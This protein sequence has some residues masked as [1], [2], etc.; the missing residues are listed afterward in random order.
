[1]I[2]GAQIK[3]ISHDC[4]AYE[5]LDIEEEP[6]HKPWYHDILTYVKSQEYPSHATENDKKTIR[7]LAMGFCL[8]GNILYKRTF[9]GLLLRCLDEKEAQRV[10]QE[11]TKGAVLH[12]PV[13][14][15]WLE[16]PQNG[17]LL[18]E[19]GKGLH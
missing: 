5:I 9:D 15:I 4:P 17:I 12:I 3:I 11:V 7:R 2:E 1:M 14:I 13:V 16:N 10:I 8:R 6:D 18:A 19:I